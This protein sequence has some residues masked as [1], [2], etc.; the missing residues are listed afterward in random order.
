MISWHRFYDP[1]TGRYLSAD[2]I[3]L[4]GG[5]NLYG[6]VG[7][8]PVNW[9]DPEGLFSWGFGGS[10]GPVTFSWNSKHPTKIDFTTDLE[11]GG[12]FSFE[13]DYPFDGEVDPPTTPFDINFGPSRWLGMSTNGDKWSVKLRLG[14]GFTPIDISKGDYYPKEL[15]D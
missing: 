4:D 15:C 9:V 3:G 13:F 7:N 14:A 2:P 10:L 11:I 8:D 5:I 12:G 6:Y 1:D